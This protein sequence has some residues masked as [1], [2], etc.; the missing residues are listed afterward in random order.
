MVSNL[1]FGSTV[2]LLHEFIYAFFPG[3]AAQVSLRAFARHDSLNF[4]P[5]RAENNQLH[6]YAVLYRAPCSQL[7]FFI[8]A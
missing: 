5:R 7:N 2:K 6:S 1:W 3:R 4:A 8:L